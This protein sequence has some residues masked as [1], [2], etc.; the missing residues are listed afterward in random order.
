MSLIS[1]A[2]RKARLESGEQPE[3]LP[4]S[5]AGA[6]SGSRRPV[7]PWL[8]ASI[9]LS[10]AAGI[11]VG[12]LLLPIG[13]P[14]A[15]PA[16]PS[17]AL[18]TEP[19]PELDP[20]I[21]PVETAP[22]PPARKPGTAETARPTP[23]DP[24]APTSAPQGSGPAAGAEVAQ[25]V[26]PVPGPAS[27]AEPEPGPEPET[28]ASV[29]GSAPAAGS[30]SAAPPDSRRER[31]RPGAREADGAFTGPAPGSTHHRRIVLPDGRE[32]ALGGIAISDGTTA[33]LINGRVLAPGDSRD[34]WRL[35][36]A[37]TGRVEIEWEGVRFFLE[38]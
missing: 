34:G 21:L 25:A 36:G 11:V 16:E 29:V 19:T 35:I 33:V 30:A 15:P 31:E 26:E 18:R 3:P 28:R 20:E 8:V 13:A 17:T 37:E 23:R 1:D 14:Q 27:P 9:S 5:R 24:V 6:P 32:L 22:L 38:L 4:H 7:W 2:L 12:V 10:L